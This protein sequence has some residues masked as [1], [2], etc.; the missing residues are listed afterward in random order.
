MATKRGIVLGSARAASAAVAIAVAVAAVSA[1]HFAD[2]PVFANPPASTV[3][4]PE[5][6]EQQRVCPGPLLALGQDSSKASAAT[7]V[8]AAATVAGSIEAGDAARWSNPESTDISAVD[9]AQS[10]RHGSP[11]L[12]SVPVADASASPP[13]V[14]ASQSQTAT[15]ETLG[16]FA[17]AAC[18][19]PTSE[20]WLVGGSTDLG[21]TSL[22]LLTNPTTVVARVDLSVYGETGRVDAPGSTG[23]LV[24][25]GEQRI[26]SLAGL[27]PNLKSPVVHVVA[28]GGR[29]A[30][31][32]EASVVQGIQPGGVE[33][34]GPTADPSRGITITGV[35][36]GASPTDAPADEDEFGDDTPTVRVLIPGDVPAAVQVGIVSEDGQASGASQQLQLEPGLATE[37]PLTDLAPGVYTVR[38]ESDQ[39]LVGSARTASIG[40]AARDFGWFAASSFL[41]DDIAVVAAPGPGSSLHLYNDDAAD[42]V[43]QLTPEGGATAEV[44]IP[45]GRSTVVQI[46]PETRYTVSGINR[47]VA[48]VGYSADGV[49]SSFP[50]NPAGALATPI[51]VY[52]R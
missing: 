36:I 20:S 28:T 48:S 1:A 16:G 24:Q 42:A 51:T 49:L 39:P 34:I 18:T 19:E 15:A 25:P 10:R 2:W 33:L 23:I 35:R 26:L 21:H 40:T 30:A 17:A 7:S 6:A 8:G 5:P 22:I 31:S 9:N 4:T 44:P 50:I 38:L 14:A 27:A 47:V 11:V 45:S 29:I 3:V 52:S 37:I 41:T 12:L 13:L 43:V 32:L 46:K